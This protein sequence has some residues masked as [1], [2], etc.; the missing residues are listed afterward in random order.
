MVVEILIVV[1]VFIVVKVLVAV[2]TA[3]LCLSAQSIVHLTVQ[4]QII[5][6]RVA[7]FF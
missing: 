1:K 5:E 3:S 6:N 7:N 4:I 2:L